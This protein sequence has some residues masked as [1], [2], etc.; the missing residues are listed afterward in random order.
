MAFKAFERSVLSLSMILLGSAF[1][2]AH[3]QDPAA[4]I[5]PASPEAC[6]ALESN[7]LS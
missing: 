3:A 1:T 4:Q 6:V 2:A 5:S 7:C